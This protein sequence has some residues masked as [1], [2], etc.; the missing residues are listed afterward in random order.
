MINN[1]EILDLGHGVGI[2]LTGGRE[3]RL[4]PANCP[5]TLYCNLTGPNT[6]DWPNP[7]GGRTWISPEADLYFP[8]LGRSGRSDHSVPEEI[9]PGAFQ[10]VAQDEYTVTMRNRFCAKFHHDK[11]E[12]PLILDKKVEVLRQAPMVLDE[13]IAFA[14]YELTVTLEAQQR[15]LPTQC[16]AIWNL[17]QVPP[18]GE[19][20]FRGGTETL[21]FGE[22]A[23]CRTEKYVAMPTPDRGGYKLGF[24]PPGRSRMRMFYWNEAS[25]V[26][27][28]I[29]REFTV[30]ERCADIP[31]PL[32]AGQEQLPA[33][34]VQVFCGNDEIGGFGEM[35]YHANYLTPEIARVTD[36]CRT[37]AFAGAR[38][39]LAALFE[40]LLHWNQ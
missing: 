16:P 20:R 1:T 38:K 25:E 30:A 36:R 28:F 31:F 33:C 18:G 12:L 13:A 35:E 22:R 19:I 11:S 7:G 15:V 2:R 21:Y 24:R 3:I 10:I 6:G 14:G 4:Q 26:P 8:S 34:P 40:Q 27:Y 29:M 39:Q 17:L 32:P 9:D 5:N 37:W 23:H